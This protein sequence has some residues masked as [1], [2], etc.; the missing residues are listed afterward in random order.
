MEKTYIFGHKKPD[1]DSVTA[2]IALSYLKNQLGHNTEPMILGNPNSETKFVLNYFNINQPNYLN[3]VKLQIKD[4]SYLKDFFM[5]KDKSIY[6]AFNYM[7]KFVIG[8]LPVVNELGNYEGIISMKDITKY[9]I[10]EN[11]NSLCTSYNNILKTLEAIEITKFKEE[12]NGKLLIASYR[13]TTFIENIELNEDTIL[14]VGDRHSIIEYAINS[15]VKLIILTGNSNISD[16]HLEI[17]KKNN[18]NIIQTNFDTA[19]TS[20]KIWLAS[21]L[22]SILIKNDVITLKDTTEVNDFI[23]ISRKNKYSNYPILNENNKCLGVLR[24]AD[25][26]DAKKK[27]VILVDHNEADQSVDGLNEA[28]IIEIIDH[29]KIGTLGTSIPINFRNMP[30]G[31]TNTI[32][33]MLFKEANIEIPNKYAGLMLSGIISDTLLFRS[34][35]TTELDKL[36]VKELSKIANI[37]YE[38]YGMEMLKAGA[39]LKG[40]TKEEILYSDFKNFT[41]DDKKIGIGQVITLNPDDIINEIDEYVILLNNIAE[42][43]NY[44]IVGLFA[45][46]L[47]NNGSYVIFND[48]SRNIFETSFNLNN[49]KQGSYLKDCISRKKQIIPNI[50][51]TLE[52]K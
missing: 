18:V 19:T 5:N 44:F 8:L 41:F 24:T 50:I 29:H 13:S 45:T 37:D 36:A 16:H 40:K 26:N 43:N 38:T 31:S 21:N 3:D 27:K 23:E 48:K 14:I 6:D 2:S 15:K 17:A 35:T 51:D 9:L 28:E 20:K 49:I 25:I 39:S 42:K 47:L 34:P 12:I 10:N 4:L 22:S 52:K 46:D 7:N 1:T 11:I 30:V 33:Q 32:I